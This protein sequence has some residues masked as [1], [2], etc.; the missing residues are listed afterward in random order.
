MLF[1]GMRFDDFLLL[2]L[3]IDFI[4]ALSPIV[5]P[6]PDCATKLFFDLFNML[7]YSIHTWKTFNSTLHQQIHF[8]CLS[9]YL[10]NGSSVFRNSFLYNL[11]FCTFIYSFT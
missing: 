2:W 3:A 7:S 1:C 9:V 11:G 10:F 6:F 5:L 8:I 4:P